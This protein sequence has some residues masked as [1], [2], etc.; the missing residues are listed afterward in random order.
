M[1]ARC[2][3]FY[4][5]TYSG[6]SNIP[7]MKPLPETISGCNQWFLLP[8]TRLWICFL[9]SFT[10]KWPLCGVLV[11]YFFGKLLIYLWS[12]C[13]E[14]HFLLKLYVA[15]QIYCQVHIA[16]QLLIYLLTIFYCQQTTS[17]IMLGNAAG[18]LLWISI[19]SAVC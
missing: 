13:E 7:N 11:N 4:W 1:Q 10:E 15:G 12:I 18:N 9:Y 16:W 8:G 5:M 17:K 14:F 19:K 3:L 6:P 2:T